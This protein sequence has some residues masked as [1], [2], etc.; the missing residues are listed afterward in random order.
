LVER[1]E[2]Q[3]LQIELAGAI[4]VASRHGAR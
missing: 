1:C 4:H 3:Q 2:A